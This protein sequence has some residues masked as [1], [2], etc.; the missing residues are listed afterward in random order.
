ML[1]KIRIFNRNTERDIK[2]RC[3]CVSI[4]DLNIVITQKY[5]QNM[6]HSDRYFSNFVI[7]E[8]IT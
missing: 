7:C 5:S 1:H 8:I 6:P 2:A 3:I 4:T